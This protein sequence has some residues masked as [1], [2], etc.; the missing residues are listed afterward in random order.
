VFLRKVLI[1]GD[2]GVDFVCKVF[3]PE[4]LRVKSLECES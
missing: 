4:A 3:I 1:A 2:L